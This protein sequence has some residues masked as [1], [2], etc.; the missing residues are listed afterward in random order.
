MK[1][2]VGAFTAA[3]LLHGFFANCA[4]SE[5]AMSTD[6]SQQHAEPPSD[7]LKK[8]IQKKKNNGLNIARQALE[9]VDSYTELKESV[10]SKKNELQGLAKRRIV[11]QTMLQKTMVELNKKTSEF[12]NNP[13]MLEVVKKL[14]IRK[15]TEMRREL[16]EIDNA[17]PKL[18]VALTEESI[19]L[20]TENMVRANEKETSSDGVNE[21]YE[22]AVTERF[23]SGAQLLNSIHLHQSF[24]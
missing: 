7:E 17:L 6:M 9:S 11:L 10:N 8:E 14:Y 13:K 12:A 2:V 21:A 3:F 18:N 16:S 5:V 4:F 20:E 22:K 24:H 23:E 19:E 1:K 15:M